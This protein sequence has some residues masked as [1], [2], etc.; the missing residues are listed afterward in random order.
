M[1]L[2]AAVSHLGTWVDRY[3]SRRVLWTWLGL[4]VVLGLY[5]YLSVAS[6]NLLSLRAGPVLG[7]TITPVSV[8][9]LGVVVGGGVLAYRSGRLLA[10]FGAS[11]LIGIAAL[12]VALGC[13]GE[14][15]EGVER[16]RVFFQWTALGPT[17]SASTAPGECAYSCPHTVE[18]LPL[19]LGYILLGDALRGPHVPA[20]R[21]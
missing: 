1:V 11:V 21:E 14:M 2:R 5:V 6:P 10:S 15:C 20:R 12:S 13:P 4:A 8:G 19:F 3:R 17:I 16:L 9:S 18:L 7:W